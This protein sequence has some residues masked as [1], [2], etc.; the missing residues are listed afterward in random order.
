L[1]ERNFIGR[2][3]GKRR[4]EYL[5]SPA[6]DF[7]GVGFSVSLQSDVASYTPREKEM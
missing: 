2:K 5:W 3:K 7:I 4:Q 1:L 6:A